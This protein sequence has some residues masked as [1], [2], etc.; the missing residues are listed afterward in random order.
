M[1][2]PG[3][4][5]AQPGYQQMPQGQVMQ[6]TAEQ[7][8]QQPVSQQP[9]YQPQSGYAQPV[10]QQ[11]MHQQPGYQQMPR[12]MLKPAEQT[13]QPQTGASQPVSGYQ[14]QYGPMEHPD[15]QQRDQSIAAPPMDVRGETG[16]EK[17]MPGSP[18]SVM[19]AEAPGMGDED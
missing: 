16:Y 11:P 4:R 6:K 2:Q 17:T 13:Y 5:Y 9:G 1:Q 14:A 7:T 10:Y 15:Y 12:T 3:T 19:P 18:T 8:Y